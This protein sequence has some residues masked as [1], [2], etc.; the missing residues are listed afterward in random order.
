MVLL[1]ILFILLMILAVL[2]VAA[3]VIGGTVGIVLFG[4]MFICIFVTVWIIKKL[5]KKRKN[6]DD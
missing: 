5:I 3:L 2:A 6:R 4:D 1:I